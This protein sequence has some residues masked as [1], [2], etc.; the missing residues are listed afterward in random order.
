M[1]VNRAF[2]L[3]GRAALV[4]GA[5]VGI[6]QA[7]AVALGAAGAKVSIHYN[8]SRAGADETLRQIRAG[9]GEGAVIQGDLTREDDA[10]AVVDAAVEKLGRLD[11]LVN[12]AGALLERATIEGCSLDLW[13]RTLTAN[14][15]SAFL[16]TKRAI[17]SLRKSGKGSIINILSLSVQTGGANGAGAYGAAK[18]GL[19][20]FTRTLARELAPQVR[21]NAVMPGVIETRH[22]EVASSAEAMEN[23]RRQT[24]LARNGKAE[25]VANAVLFL[26][27]DAAS[28]T[29]GSLL[30]INGGRFLR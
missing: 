18:G 16:V 3:S 29:N 30:D 7:V 28:F 20:T 24:P 4:T 22:H 17:P 5:G 8:S 1:T 26:A 6:G 23:Y 13:N 11:I 27:S 14:L 12:N 25:E 2:D 15:T 21:T 19:L 9:G 10:N